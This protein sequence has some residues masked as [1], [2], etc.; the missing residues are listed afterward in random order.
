[1]GSHSW[2]SGSTEDGNSF[3]N[4]KGQ[5]TYMPNEGIEKTVTAVIQ[6]QLNNDETFQFHAIELNEIPQPTMMG[7]SLL[8]KMCDATKE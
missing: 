6:F 7:L 1:M 5:V 2:S 3:V 4:L 8:E